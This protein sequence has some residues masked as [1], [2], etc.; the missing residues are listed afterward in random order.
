MSV[1]PITIFAKS[2]FEL[3]NVDEACLFGH[4]YRINVTPI[5]FVETP[6][7]LEK[8]VAEGRTPQRGVGRIAYRTTGAPSRPLALSQTLH[9]G[10]SPDFRAPDDDAVA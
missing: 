2:A 10:P 3:L 5:F 8:Q 9:A 7:D 6:A 1:G 4:F